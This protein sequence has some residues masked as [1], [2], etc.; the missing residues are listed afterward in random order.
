MV[1]LGHEALPIAIEALRDND[2]DVRVMAIW[3]CGELRDP[4]AIQ[5]LVECLRDA[6]TN[7]PANADYLH[8]STAIQNL[9]LESMLEIGPQAGEPLL[10]VSKECDPRALRSIPDQ[11]AAA[12]GA[13]AVPALMGMLDNPVYDIRATVARELGGLKDKRA[14]DAL[15]RLLSDPD[16]VPGVEAAGALGDIGDA[17]AIP[18]LL[19]M[20]HRKDTEKDVRLSVAVALGRMGQDEGLK[21]IQTMLQSPERWDRDHVTLALCQ[22]PVQGTFESLLSEVRDDTYVVQ[23]PRVQAVQA[24][25]ALHDPRAIPALKECLNDTYPEVRHGAADALKELGAEPTTASQP[26]KP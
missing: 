2:L 18:P 17:K 10:Q 13:A 26:E 22:T 4:A 19:K 11:L 7:P 15:I 21:Y 23:S 1:K 12:W 5:P 8:D 9:C 14:T 3:A 20:L 16:C 24:L 25:G 6:K